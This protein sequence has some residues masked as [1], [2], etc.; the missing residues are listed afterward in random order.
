MEIRILDKAEQ[1]GIYPDAYRL[2]AD[3]DEEFV[4]PLSSR[5]SS[6]Q[7]ALCDSA[8]N[9]NGIHPYFEELKSSALPP[10]LKM[11]N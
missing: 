2:L 11:A 5:S 6:T 4:P 9:A 7:Q 3:A 1:Q 10:L 8:Q